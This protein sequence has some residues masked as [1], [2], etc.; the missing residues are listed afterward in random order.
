[1]KTKSTRIATLF[2][3]TKLHTLQVILLCIASLLP[4]NNSLA[5]NCPTPQEGDL[6]LRDF[7]FKSGE[8][9]PELRLHYRTIGAPVRDPAGTA[10][11]AVLLLHGTTGSGRFFLSPQ[12]CDALL[13]PGQP[14][15]ATRYFIILPDSIGLGKS[16][17]PSD[18]LHARFPRYNYEDMVI[19]QYRLLTEKLGINHLRLVMGTSMGG[20][21]TWLWGT[22]YPDLM[23]TLVP[24]AALPVEIGGQNRIWR[25]VVIEAVRNDPA[26]KN[27]E[28]TSPPPGLMPALQVFFFMLNSRLQLQN[29]APTAAAA[30]QL[31]DKW[32]QA[33]LVQTDANDFLYQ[34]ESM[35]DYNPEP[36][37]E[38]IQARVLAINFA[39]DQINP[40][41][42]GILESAVKRIKRGQAV[43]VPASDKTR[44]HLTL[45]F[46][47]LWKQYLA[48]L[49]AGSTP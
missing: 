6:V 49:M 42:L 28:Y 19:A 29:Q 16:S 39:D 1:M 5:A 47:E 30:D 48:E 21:L 31:L 11:N 24:V 38:K 7:Q 36:D 17:K 3:T 18:G 40:A 34:W 23:E 4:M 14:L 25:R 43:L 26:W 33:V 2:H 8:V 46:P 22:K 12:F 10:R 32:V 27:G 37:L 44:G 20:S 13:G 45:A 41:E 35:R 9:L 15:D